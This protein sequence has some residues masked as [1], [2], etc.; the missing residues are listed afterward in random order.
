MY[1]SAAIDSPPRVLGVLIARNEWP[2]LGISITHALVNHVD[3]LIVVDHSSTDE[4][5]AGLAALKNR[6]GD[7]IQVLHLCEGTFHHEETNLMLKTMYEDRDFDWVYPIDADEF[8]ITPNNLSLKQLLAQVPGD[9]K[10]VRYELH[11][12][13]APSDFVENDFNRY[14][15]LNKKAVVIPDLRLT[16]ESIFE[17]VFSEDLNFFDVPFDSKVIF[18]LPQDSWTVGGSHLMLGVDRESEFKFSAEETFVA[19]LPFLSRD[20]LMLRVAQ[21][22]DLAKSDYSRDHG[23][24]SQVVNQMFI[25]GRLDEYWKRNSLATD[26]SN[27]E[28]PSP[29]TTTDDRLASVLENAVTEFLPTLDAIENPDSNGRPKCVRVT[30][31]SQG[32]HAIRAMALYKETG[33]E[34]AITRFTES[35]NEVDELTSQ[36]NNLR[37]EEAKLTAEK[38]FLL[39]MNDQLRHE[40]SMMRDST[41]WRWTRS[42]RHI[43]RLAK[44]AKKQFSG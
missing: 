6:W 17:S 7:K 15:E 39:I 2:L 3:E 34:N 1:S 18:R 26:P 38:T 33:V 43:H 24:Q 25:Q 5:Q 27:V 30:T 4:T 44:S 29:K 40:L 36:V 42:L 10:V 20:R 21:G 13:V 14:S 41:S 28:V 31:I 32:V 8:L 35:L 22:Q 9:H 23:W 16:H 12:F 37:S 19:H 11:N